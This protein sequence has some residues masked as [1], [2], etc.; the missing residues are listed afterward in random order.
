[1]NKDELARLIGNNVRYYRMKQKMTQNELAQIVGVNASAITRIVGG[2]RMM[3]TP[4]LIDVANALSISTDALLFDPKA[5]THLQ[6]IFMLLR[7]QTN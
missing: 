1:M 7:G 2:T 3:S 5:P 4:V 6:N